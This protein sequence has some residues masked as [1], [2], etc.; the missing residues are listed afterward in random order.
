MSTTI[1]WTD[2]TW[3]PIVGCSKVSPGCDHCY[4]IGVAHRGLAAQ[5]RGLTVRPADGGTDWTGE[6]RVVDHLLDQPLRWRRPRR[7]FVNS[8]SDLFHPQVSQATIARVFAVMARAPQHTFQV[9][10]KRPQRMAGLLGDAQALLEELH[11]EADA[12]AVY[13]QWPLP[14]VWLGTSIES[15]QYAWRA[16]HLRNTPSAVRFISAEPLLG[17][18]SSLNLAGIDWL[19][20]GG[21]SGP[22]SRP[23][24]PDWARQLRDSCTTRC[25][26]CSSPIEFDGHCWRH[27]S[28]QG[29]HTVCDWTPDIGPTDVV[30]ARGPAFFFKQWGDW[31]PTGR[32]GIGQVYPARERIVGPYDREGFGEE[33]RRVGK[34]AAGRELDGRTWDE[35]PTAVTA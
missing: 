3:N 8:L 18:L 13:D 30:A 1:E 27:G 25:R 31:A 12:E 32:R 29:Y 35:M 9:L 22:G 6:V 4:A 14:N 11:D 20:V 21:E 17:P 28:E 24:H 16:N 26:N 10:T 7:V 34:R 5:H 19:I 23:M 33:I 2:E 15:D